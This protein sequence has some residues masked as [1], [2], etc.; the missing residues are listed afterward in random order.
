MV[1]RPAEQ[2]QQIPLGVVRGHGGGR[3]RAPPDLAVVAVPPGV[4]GGVVGRA[5][6]RIRARDARP[7]SGSS[8]TIVTRSLA[9]C[10]VNLKARPSRQPW[11]AS[12][13]Q[14]QLKPLLRVPAVA[15]PPRPCRRSQRAAALAAADSRQGAVVG[16]PD[17]LDLL[18]AP[19]DGLRTRQEP[20]LPLDPDGVVAGAGGGLGDGMDEEPAPRGDPLGSGLEPPAHMVGGGHP[21][22]EGGRVEPPVAPAAGQDVLGEAGGLARIGDRGGCRVNAQSG[23]GGKIRLVPI[24]GRP[25]RRGNS[26]ADWRCRVRRRCSWSPSRRG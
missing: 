25:A 7:R 19:K 17:G 10:T 14:R 24:A 22:L 11:V 20:L 8:G 1:L 4:D 15:P 9:T 16:L 23:V 21:L 12:P 6:R 3:L 2:G 13:N 26:R 5:R 18:D